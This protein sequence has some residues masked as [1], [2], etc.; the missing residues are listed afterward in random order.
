MATLSNG[1]DCDAFN[2]LR[3][4]GARKKCRAA[5]CTW[6][7]PTRAEWRA[8]RKAAGE[9]KKKRRP[10]GTC[11]PP[12]SELTRHAGNDDRCISF[13]KKQGCRRNGCTWLGRRAGGCVAGQ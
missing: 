11:V 9:K 7:R 4:K 13:R 1:G 8:E 5:G 10:P 3:R 6:D 2:Q 12:T